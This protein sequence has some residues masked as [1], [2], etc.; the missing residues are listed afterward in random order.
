MTAVKSETVTFRIQP[1]IKSQLRQMAE[2]EHRSLASML[3]VMIRD[4]HGR[5]ISTRPESRPPTA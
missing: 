2:H 1:E 5:H 4:Y 3:E